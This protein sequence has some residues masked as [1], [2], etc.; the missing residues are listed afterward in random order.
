MANSIAT[1]SITNGV[2][3]GVNHLFAQ[4]QE[5]FGWRGGGI[6]RFRSSSVM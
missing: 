1:V 6:S 5:V 4:K 2:R 3:S